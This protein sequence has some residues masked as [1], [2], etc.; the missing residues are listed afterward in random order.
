MRVDGTH[1]IPTEAAV[2]PND[3][4][5]HRIVFGSAVKENLD[6]GLIK[7]ED[8]F[9]LLKLALVKQN[10]NQ[11]AEDSRNLRAVHTAQR[12]ALERLPSRR[13]LMWHEFEKVDKELQLKSVGD[14]YRAYLC[15]LWDQIR[16]DIRNYFSTSPD[17]HAA[18]HSM[19]QHKTRVAVAV[20]AFWDPVWIDKLRVF[21]S[22]A[23][24]PNCSIVSEPKCAAAALAFDTMID[25][26]KQVAKEEQAAEMEKERS[27][28]KVVLDIGH[29]TAVSL[30][31]FQLS[32]IILTH[33]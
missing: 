13:V 21:L 30:S 15:F 12:K 5:T 27:L 19:M 6:L 2:V 33:E 1:R 18:I 17:L 31:T 20:P 22:D 26:V 8:V 3:D 29:G 11:S 25:M 16:A 23:G 32:N 10:E 24:F 7:E 4:G 14:V 28:I 9:R